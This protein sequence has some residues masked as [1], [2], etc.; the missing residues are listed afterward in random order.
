L[1]FARVDWSGNQQ[2]SLTQPY[3]EGVFSRNIM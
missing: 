2:P 3:Y 1:I